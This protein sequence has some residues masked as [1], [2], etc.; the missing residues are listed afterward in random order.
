MAR[1]IVQLRRVWHAKRRGVES[2]VPSL[3]TKERKSM[4]RWR[5]QLSYR[6]VGAGFEFPG[7]AANFVL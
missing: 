3:L 7:L 6:R 5:E 1:E 4:A 2:V